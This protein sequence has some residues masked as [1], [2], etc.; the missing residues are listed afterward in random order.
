MVLLIEMST[1]VF[2]NSAEN[3]DRRERHDLCYQKRKK[4]PC[5]VKIECL[6]VGCRH[7]DNRIYS[8]DIEEKCQKENE[9]MFFLRYLTECMSKSQNTVP[10]HML[11]RL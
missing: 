4:K 11:S 7:I 8:V 5:A 2:Y 1:Y 3:K 10:Y 9:N 6:S